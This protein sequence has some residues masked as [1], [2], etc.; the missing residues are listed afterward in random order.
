[1][2]VVSNYPH[3]DFD[4]SFEVAHDTA[5]A[6]LV[7]ATEQASGLIEQVSVFDDYRDAERGLR[8][9]ALRYRLRAPDRTLD[10]EE[11]ATVRA[12]LIDEATRHGATLRGAE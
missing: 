3:V 1:M 2:T 12:Q 8:A 9:V 10:A 7:A 11:I 5:A 6:E 4:L